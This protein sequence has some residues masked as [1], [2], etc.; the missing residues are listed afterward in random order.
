MTHRRSHAEAPRCKKDANKSE[1]QC[2][3]ETGHHWN[4]CTMGEVR[5]T[6]KYTHLKNTKSFLP[7]RFASDIGLTEDPPKT[8]KHKKQIQGMSAQDFPK[9]SMLAQRLQTCAKMFQYVFGVVNN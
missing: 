4:N 6:K 8:K 2:P 9:R 1:A 7:F 5:T 3:L